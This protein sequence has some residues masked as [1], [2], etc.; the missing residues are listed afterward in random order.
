[1]AR[2]WRS[3]IELVEGPTLA[4]SD[5]AGATSAARGSS[6][7]EPDDRGARGGARARHHPS[8]PE[9]RQR[10]G[11]RRTAPSRCSTSVSPRPSCRT[12]IS[13]RASAMNSPTITAAMT[14]L[15][16]ILGTAA[17][18]A[19]E[20]AKGKTVDRTCRHLGLRRRARRD[21]HGPAVVRR[22]ERVPETLAPV[23]MREIDLGELPA[24]TPAA[25]ARSLRALPGQEIRSGGC[26]TS[27]KCD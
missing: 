14:Q 27:A 1:M 22:R 7:R 5:R 6:D 8:R 3:C 2:R 20:Q 4:E 16:V 10:Q 9:A 23:M 17:Y 25:S 11:A 26:A 21:A 24:S 13:R 15:G 18:M 12:R 19:P